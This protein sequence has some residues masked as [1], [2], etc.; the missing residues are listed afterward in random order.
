MIYV[1]STYSVITRDW[2]AI[3]LSELDIESR[4]FW[5]M[6]Q[7]YKAA[8]KYVA[9]Q[10]KKGVCCF[11]PIVH[12]HHMAVE[13]NFPKTFEFWADINHKYL[14]A[15]TEMH[16]LK[17]GCWEDSAGIRDEINYATKK[18]IEIKYVDWEG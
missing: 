18:G 5:K 2:Y 17:M 14:D 11:S 1:A 12:S 16:V 8:A 6:E 4:M 13:Y 9:M 7:R 15:C 3:G 10:T